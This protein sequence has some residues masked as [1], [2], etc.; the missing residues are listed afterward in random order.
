MQ[1]KTTMRYY[2]T[3]IRMSK[4]QSTDTSTSAGKETEQ[5][6]LAITV[7]RKA[8]WYATL[9]GSVVSN[10]TKCASIC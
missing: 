5:Q 6:E 2:V 10:K 4:I 8:K 7:D 3:A 9:E 1:I